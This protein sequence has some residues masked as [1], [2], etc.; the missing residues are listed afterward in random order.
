MRLGLLV[1]SLQY[2]TRGW[3]LQL[4]QL[5][6]SVDQLSSFQMRHEY[7]RSV[8]LSNAS[9]IGCFDMPD[10]S[11]CVLVSSVPAQV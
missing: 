7:L 1:S 3:S 11:L 9:L 10:Y 4:D 5:F 2:E 6:E 8:Q